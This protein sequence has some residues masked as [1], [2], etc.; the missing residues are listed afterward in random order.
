MG[1]AQKR[2]LAYDKLERIM[3][4]DSDAE[5]K[6]EDILKLLEDITKYNGMISEWEKITTPQDLPSNIAELQSQLNKKQEDE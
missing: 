3:N 6:E 1:I 4:K 2:L 5:E